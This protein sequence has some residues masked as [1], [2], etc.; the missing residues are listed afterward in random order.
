M[1]R[2]T[3]FSVQT[4]LFNVCEY[5]HVWSRWIGNKIPI[6]LG[7]HSDEEGRMWTHGHID[8]VYIIS[9]HPNLPSSIVGFPWYMVESCPQTRSLLC[10]RGSLS[11]QL[12]ENM[13]YTCLHLP[14]RISRFAVAVTHWLRREKISRGTILH[15]HHCWR[16]STQK[17]PAFAEGDLHVSIADAPTAIQIKTHRKHINSFL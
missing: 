7:T 12:K 8:F 10:P 2:K 16:K 15:L 13:S 4:V 5:S 14:S 3:M 9:W 6:F 1:I 17:T 11:S